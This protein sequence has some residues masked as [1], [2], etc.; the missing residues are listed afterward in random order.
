MDKTASIIIVAQKMPLILFWLIFRNY[1]FSFQNGV[2]M[3]ALDTA[4]TSNGHWK[5]LMTDI[6]ITNVFPRHLYSTRTYGNKFILWQDPRRSV[7][8]CHLIRIQFM[9]GTAELAKEEMSVI[10]ERIKKLE[11]RLNFG[12]TK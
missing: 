12:G 2:A 8:R 1:S 9:K 3:E 10:E 6:F 11:K 7:R 4:N 5:M